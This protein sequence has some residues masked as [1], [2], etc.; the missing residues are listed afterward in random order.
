MDFASHPDQGIVVASYRRIS[1]AYTISTST[2]GLS[3]S[4]LRWMTATTI[5][6]GGTGAQKPTRLP[7]TCHGNATHYSPHGRPHCHQE[8][9][10]LSHSTFVRGLNSHTS[11]LK[12]YDVGHHDST[13]GRLH[14][15]ATYSHE[16][17]HLPG[18]RRGLFCRL[19]D[20][21][22][23]IWTITHLWLQNPIRRAPSVKAW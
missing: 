5:P 7:C 2:W 12:A 22:V 16:V 23:C 19:S 11:I 13:S 9:L 1:G 8:K 20:Y 15:R 17:L 18:T 10:L 21:V 6:R 4:L 3:A 14:R